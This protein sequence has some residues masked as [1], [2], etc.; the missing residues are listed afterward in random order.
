MIPATCIRKLIQSDIEE[1]SKTLL[2]VY[3]DNII[4]ATFTKLFDI[5]IVAN[6]FFGAD[7]RL[8]TLWWAFDSE[9]LS[10]SFSD[11]L[12][13]KKATSEPDIKAENK[14]RINNI[15]SE[16]NAPNE[17]GFIILANKIKLKLGSGSIF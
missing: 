6:N 2:I 17:N 13:E 11:G 16:I 1:K 3:V 15:P 9:E 12:S 7:K 14:S 5:N 4:I 10:V 8:F